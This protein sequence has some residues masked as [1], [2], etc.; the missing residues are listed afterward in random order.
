MFKHLSRCFKHP[1][2]VY[3][4]Q[5]GVFKIST[6]CL[7]R[8]ENIYKLLGK[9]FKIGKLFGSGDE[10]EEKWFEGEWGWGGGGLCT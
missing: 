2:I 7:E 9:M 5:Q 8:C 1:M 6:N 10:M 4:K 3:L